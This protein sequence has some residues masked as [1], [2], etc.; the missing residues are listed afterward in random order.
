[1]TLLREAAT[2]LSVKVDVVGPDLEDGRVEEGGEIGRE[3]DVDA[4]LMV[5]EG[6]EG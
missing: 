4:D 3:V 2:L 5:L 6:N 1:V